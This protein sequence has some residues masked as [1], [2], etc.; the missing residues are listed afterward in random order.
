M[1]LDFA[2]LLPVR[3]VK[4]TK[5]TDDAMPRAWRIGPHFDCHAVKQRREQCMQNGFRI[6]IKSLL[7]PGKRMS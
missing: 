7:R 4:I 5:S 3:G 2:F 1:S 6:T